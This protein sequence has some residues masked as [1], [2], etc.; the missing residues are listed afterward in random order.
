MN[1]HLNI[2]FINALKSGM[3]QEDEFKNYSGVNDEVEIEFL[4]T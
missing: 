4:P 3:A 2:E 1:K